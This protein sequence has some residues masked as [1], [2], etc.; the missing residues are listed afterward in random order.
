MYSLS[1][2]LHGFLV[3]LVGKTGTSIKNS[4]DFINKVKALVPEDTYFMVSFNVCSLFTSVPV[5]LAVDTCKQ[6]L[7]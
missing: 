4:S 1:Q 6:R 3:P 5:D 2:Y 7:R